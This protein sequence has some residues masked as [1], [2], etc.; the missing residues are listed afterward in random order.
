MASLWGVS[1]NA[2]LLVVVSRQYTVRSAVVHSDKFVINLQSVFAVLLQLFDRFDRL[3]ISA[4]THTN[5]NTNTKLR[6]SYCAAIFTFNPFMG[7]IICGIVT[8]QVTTNT[9]LQEIQSF[10]KVV[11]LRRRQCFSRRSTVTRF[12]A[13]G[14]RFAAAAEAA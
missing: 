12:V 13:V 1:T 2:A 11:T 6:A 8:L 7:C 14:G 9:E 3:F 4:H 10:V 5:F